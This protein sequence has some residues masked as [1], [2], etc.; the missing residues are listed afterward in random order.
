MKSTDKLF[1]LASRF[2]LKLSL[3]QDT[4]QAM[5]AADFFFGKGHNLETFQKSLGNLS[6]SGTD[7]VG[8]Q[9][10]A[11]LMANYFNKVNEA[12]KKGSFKDP[13][14]SATVSVEVKPGVGARWIVQITPSTFTQV[15]M[16]ELNKQY[17]AL[18]GKSWAQ[19][20]AAASAAAKAAKT[21]EG[22]GTKLIM[23][24]GL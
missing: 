18:T 13:S 20:E 10:L 8:D 6:V 2:A 15:A 16:A 19:G 9:S 5:E 12:N 7:A 17:Q 24:K 1:K 22:P 4:T 21:M 11:L 3:G 23:D 14:V